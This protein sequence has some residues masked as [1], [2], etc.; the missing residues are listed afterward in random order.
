MTYELPSFPTR[1]SSDLAVPS[2]ADRADR[3]G[4]GEGF[5]PRPP[6]SAAVGGQGTGGGRRRGPRLLAGAAGGVHASGAHGL[7]AAPPLLPAAGCASRRSRPPRT[8][9]HGEGP[10]LLDGAAVVAAQLLGQHRPGALA[11]RLLRGLPDGPPLGVEIGRAH[12]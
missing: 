8:S 6:G 10:V 11:H 1:R 7:R 3:R 9:P 2:G 4:V 5:L 12:V